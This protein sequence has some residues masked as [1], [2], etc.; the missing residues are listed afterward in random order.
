MVEYNL[1]QTYIYIY[2][3]YTPSLGWEHKFADNMHCTSIIKHALL[4]EQKATTS[5]F[6]GR[7]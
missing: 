5:A 1:A 4:V 3:S 6:H 2:N 7:C